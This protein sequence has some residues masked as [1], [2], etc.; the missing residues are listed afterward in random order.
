LATSVRYIAD[1]IL[2][3]RINCEKCF[4]GTDADVVCDC[5]IVLLLARDKTRGQEAVAALEKEG[6]HPKFHQ[7]DID[8]QESIKALRQFLVDTYGG[9]DLLVNNAGIAYKV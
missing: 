4:C 6:L 7:L 8:D 5:K 2:V 1:S 9:L 3:L